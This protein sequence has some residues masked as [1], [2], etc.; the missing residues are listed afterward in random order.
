ML[1]DIT[2]LGLGSGLKLQDILDKM[3]K[4]DEVP[5][6]RLKDEEA[7]LKKQL[8]A[9]DDLDKALLDIKNQAMNLSMDSTFLNRNVDV[10]NSSVLSAKA[11]EGAPTGNHTITVDQLATFSTWA[12]PSFSSTDNVVNDSGQDE[13]FAYHVGNGDTISITVPDQ[14][15]LQGLADLINNDPNNPGVTAEIINNGDPLNPYQ[16]VLKANNTG[17]ANRITIDTQLPTYNLTEIQGANGASLNAQL[18]VD[19]INYQRNSNNDIT[20]IIGGV[21]LNLLGTG[22]STLSVDSDHKSLEE[23]IVNLVD[24]VNKVVQSINKEAGYDENNKPE[25]LTNVGTIRS[26]KSRLID[27]LSTTVNVKGSIHSLY[28]LGLEIKRDGTITIDQTKLDQAISEH[29]DDVKTFFLGDSDNNIKGFG[30]IVNDQLR[31]MTQS[32]SGLLAVQ[33]NATQDRINRIDN[34]IQ[35]AEEQ[36]NRRYDI[37]ARRFAELDKFMSSM[38]NLSSYLTTEFNSLSGHTKS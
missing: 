8:A 19:G 6:D 2:A 7:T 21:T 37:L 25:L 20:D 22:S 33:K 35:T 16:L 12:G 32:G 4:A 1:G 17:E 31:E 18:T 30:D 15:T 29:Y 9:F 23:D 36:L 24:N 28:D 3:K 10:S 11:T 27:M 5:I 14:T 13:T 26:L 34:Q 38:Q